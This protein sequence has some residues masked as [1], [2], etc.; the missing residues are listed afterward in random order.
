MVYIVKMTQVDG[1]NLMTSDHRSPVNNATTMTVSNRTLTSGGT[2]GDELYCMAP[3][4]I[5]YQQQ[6]ERNLLTS[7]N[8]I[9]LSG[10]S[11]GN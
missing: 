4:G 3:H 2:I 10:H 5:I 9:R 6:R 11:P 7:I 1:Q 8:N